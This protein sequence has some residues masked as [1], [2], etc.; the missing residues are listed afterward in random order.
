MWGSIVTKFALQKCTD[1]GTINELP[2]DSGLQLEIIKYKI[3]TYMV[4]LYVY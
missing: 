3:Y 4:V 1:L 2:E